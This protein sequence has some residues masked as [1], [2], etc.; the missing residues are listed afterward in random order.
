MT[1]AGRGKLPFIVAQWVSFG[2]NAGCLE[3]N[4]FTVSKVNPKIA[5]KWRPSQRSG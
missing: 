3:I 1:A 5:T 2:T 4:A